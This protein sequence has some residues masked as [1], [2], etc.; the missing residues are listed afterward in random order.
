MPTDPPE[1][2]GN[3][4]PC[5]GSTVLGQE[6]E[7]DKPEQ[8]V[9][10]EEGAG[11][12]GDPL[13]VVPRTEPEKSIPPIETAAKADRSIVVPD[14][15]QPGLFDVLPEA[16]GHSMEPATKDGAIDPCHSETGTVSGAT[17]TARVQAGPQS[18]D[19]DSIGLP[20][21]SVADEPARRST[22]MPPRIAGRPRAEEWT[23]DELLTLPE[24]AALFW[25][26][27]PI[28]TNTLRTAGRDGSLAITKVAGKFFTTPMA[29]RRM[30]LDEAAAVGLGVAEAVVTSPEAV[31]Q[32][33]LAEA[34]A[35]GR[36]RARPRRA[37]KR[38]VA[39]AVNGRAGQ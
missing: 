25:P 33:K 37:A 31:F 7:P 26:A 1:P 13:T 20:E 18:L 5:R 8:I 19:V 24:A 2:M 6:D 12:L 10:G 4:E 22:R 38:S 39:P 17:P 21:F 15:D 35:L 14:P 9:A 36:E 3:E 30:G 16:Y 28:T 29:I 32:M 11:S 34:K 23:D 27:G